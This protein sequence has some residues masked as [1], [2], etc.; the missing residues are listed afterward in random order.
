MNI[1]LVTVGTELLLGF[2]VDTNSAW[3]GTSLAAIGVHVVRRTAV[4]DNPDAIRDAVDAALARTGMVITTGG[5]GPTRD[6]ITKH[7]VA[8]L[9]H[10]PLQFDDA[11][12]AMLGERWARLGRALVESNRSQAMVPAGATVLTNRW[13]S[14]PGLWLESPRGVVIMLPGV[15]TEMMKLLSHEVIPRLAP[16]TSGAVIRSIVV[17][18]NGIGESALAEQIGSLEDELLPLSLAY[19]PNVAG[20]DLR[21]TAWGLDPAAADALLADGAARLHATI[22]VHAWGDDDQDLVALLLEALRARGKSLAVAE[23]CTGG[24][25]GARITDVAGASDV[26]LGGVLVYA[27]AAK[28]VLLGVDPRLLV[29]HGAVSGEVAEAMVRGVA[30]ALGADAAVA[31][32]GIAGPG[33]GSVEKPVGTVWLAFLVDGVVTSRRMQFSGERAEVRARA[34]QAAIFGLWRSVASANPALL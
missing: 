7:V 25:L 4:A 23:S 10:M 13:G 30:V 20:V 2:T 14:A 12:W 5:L 22:G 8:E 24:L 31:I 18:T 19:L 29:D 6:D 9:L 21:L 1:E 28:E 11:I 3:I 33:G 15:P 32:T 34:V 26:F 17:H 16:R 27:D